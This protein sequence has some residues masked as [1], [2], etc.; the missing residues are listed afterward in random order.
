MNH[1]IDHSTL[2]IAF[3]RTVAASREEVFDAW[4]RPEQLSQWWDPTGAK[5]V[6]CEIDLRP[7]GSFCFVNEGHSPPFTGTYERVEPPAKLVFEAL[8]S[9]GTVVLDTVAEGTR[10]R[11]TIRCSSAEQLEHLLQ[12]GAATNTDRTLDNL[13]RFAGRRRGSLAP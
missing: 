1:H 6:R 12:V 10:M 11:V 9:I 5:L 7:G 4:T 13:V 8:G 2:T 3:E